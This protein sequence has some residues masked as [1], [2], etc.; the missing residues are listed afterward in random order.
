VWLYPN[1]PQARLFE[2]FV[3]SQLAYSWRLQKKQLPQEILNGTI[4]RSPRWCWRTEG[5]TSSTT[6]VNSWPKV[7]PTR[8]SAII[9]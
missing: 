7:V 4:S 6:P 8:V 3:F 1:T 5:P 2:G 9:P